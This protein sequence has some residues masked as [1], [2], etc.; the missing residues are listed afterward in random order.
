MTQEITS[1][2]YSAP[3]LP[4]TGAKEGRA[5]GRLYREHQ[6]DKKNVKSNFPETNLEDLEHKFLA[7]VFFSVLIISNPHIGYAAARLFLL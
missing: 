1:T 5:S 2:L 6:V 4:V 7:A 3:P